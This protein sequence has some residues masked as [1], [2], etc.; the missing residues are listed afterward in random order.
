MSYQIAKITFGV[1]GYLVSN[2]L[3]KKH[4]F[5]NIIESRRKDIAHALAYPGSDHYFIVKSSWNPKA[6]VYV[7]PN[8]PAPILNYT[9]NDSLGYNS[10]NKIKDYIK[11]MHNDKIHLDF[12]RTAHNRVPI[13]Y[14]YMLPGFSNTTHIRIDGT[15]Q[16]L[17][18]LRSGA[19]P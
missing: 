1:T 3:L 14:I 13:G 6:A 10:N 9:D 16:T 18:V 8:V 2:S 7:V 5:D 17:Y 4:Q 15:M 12:D 19:P 11:G